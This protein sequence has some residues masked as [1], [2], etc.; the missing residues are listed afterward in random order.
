[1]IL[2]WGMIEGEFKPMMF[3]ASAIPEEEDV[4]SCDMIRLIDH[5]KTRVKR[6]SERFKFLADKHEGAVLSW[7][8]LKDYPK[9]IGIGKY[10]EVIF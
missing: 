2:I 7:Y 5:K 10:E 8:G 9:I 3:D 4:V 1:M 6:I